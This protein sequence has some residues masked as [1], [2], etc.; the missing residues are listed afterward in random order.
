MTHQEKI[1]K[2]RPEREI[3]YRFQLPTDESDHK[4]FSNAFEMLHTL[5]DINDL[6]LNYSRFE[7]TYELSELIREKIG[8]IIYEH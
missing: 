3:V 6:C 8:F 2:T 4:V 5:I 7:N 1:E